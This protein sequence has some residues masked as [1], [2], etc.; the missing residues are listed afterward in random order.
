MRAFQ[1]LVADVV[2]GG[3]LVRHDGSAAAYGQN[4]RNY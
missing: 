3:Q 2:S 4:D 1:G